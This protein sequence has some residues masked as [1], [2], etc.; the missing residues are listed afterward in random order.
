MVLIKRYIFLF[1]LLIPLVLGACSGESDPPSLF[2]SPESPDI[3]ETVRPTPVPQRIL[4]ICLG[5]EP[6]SL[7]LYGDLSKSAQM[8]RQA[9]YDSPVDS[10]DFS[11]SSQLLDPLP[12]LENGLVQIKQVEVFPGENIA[13][14]KGDRTILANGVVYRP[15]G[16]D[17]DECWEEFDEQEAVLL[18]Q[19][20]ITYKIRDG[21]T[22]SDGTPLTTA[23][24]IFSYLLA[25]EV[26]GFSGPQ[27][28]RFT[29]SY[30]VLENGDILWKGVP[31]YQ[32]IYA[33]EDMFF[34]PLP[35]HLWFNLTREELLTSAQT[36]QQP[37]GWGPFKIIEWVRGDHI[38]LTRNDHYHGISK[39]FPVFDS[40]VFRFVDGGE[41]ALAGFYS[42]ECQIVA[43]EPGLISF[44]SE[45]LTDQGKNLLK[46]HQ[47]AG[48]AW[49][50]L[51]FGIDSLGSDPSLFSTAELRS[52]ASQ[53]VDRE[54]IASSRL[55]AGEVVDDF[56]YPGDPRID[57]QENVDSYQ[58]V[59]AGITLRDLGWVDED[60]DPL[61]PRISDG[62][63]G[64]I[65][66]TPLQVT[67]LAAG[68]GDIPFTVE[69]ISEGLTSCGFKV[70][71]EMLPAAEMLEFGP[72]GPVFGRNF[73][74]AYFSWAVG[75]YQLCR[76]F[77][78]SEIPGL[79]PEHPKGWGGV[80][81]PGYSNPD[82]DDYCRD[83]HTN[84]PDS[85][86]NLEA[87]TQMGTIFKEEKPVLPLFFRVDLLISDPDLEGLSDGNYLPFWNIEE[88]H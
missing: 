43:N 38:T 30:E 74:L 68:E 87:H 84:L 27:K 83:A 18:D 66:G 4:S 45:L 70:D 86:V 19:V 2:S 60:G 26:Y 82:F 79:Y 53:C 34:S 55:D 52:I 11:Q 15:A 41:E 33:Y 28:V 65:D 31:G 32:G 51:S 10:V 59:E 56:Y 81:A 78:T 39:N 14:A 36:T 21:L 5:E 64:L 37:I 49:E 48:S 88:L 73:D 71:I 72:D 23:D 9:I 1:F 47:I 16:C 13:D 62:V 20:E 67:L 63:N 46:I 57:D 76:L 61:T 80:N 3:V 25:T 44:Q 8:I 35:E 29:S 85:G 22:W 24:S 17:K 12:F 58:P 7:F 54:Q 42:G 50:Q 77:T 40:L 75:H 69:M 6:D